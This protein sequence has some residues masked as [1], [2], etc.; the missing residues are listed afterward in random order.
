MFV[1]KK[2]GILC[3]AVATVVAA[4]S[5]T[6]CASSSSG[7]SQ[8]ST[9]TKVVQ[10]KQLTVGTVLSNEP[11]G[12]KDSN[13]NPT[14]YDV[15]VA[16]LLAKS[17]NAKIKIVD[18]T[19]AERIPALE[20]GKVDVV[21]GN[22]TITDDRAQKVNFTNPYDA[23]AAG[24][25]VKPSSAI[26]HA[27]ELSG[28]KVGAPKGTTSETSCE[29]LIASGVKMSLQLFDNSDDMEQAVKNGQLDACVEDSP[30]CVYKA[31][32]YASDFKYVGTP[33]EMLIPPFYN[34]MGVRK[35]DQEWL[36]YLNQF[37]FD[38]N[39]NGKNKAAY[40]KWFG[41]PWSVKLNP[42]Y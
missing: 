30:L 19:F 34:A 10:S 27:S 35:N 32:K 31:K 9:L 29:N 17:L 20:T 8:S 36:N 25:L 40:V 1:K 3:A 23:G 16:N 26:A 18:V 15:D 12:T 13:G 41:A 24:I 22:F 21:I 42:D 33:S 7:G 38:I 14:G 39:T 4:V 5:L 37:I 28:K 6:S 11:Y 2:K